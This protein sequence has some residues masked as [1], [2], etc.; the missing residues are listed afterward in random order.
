MAVAEVFAFA[1]I[2]VQVAQELE[3]V[4]EIFPLAAPHRSL[5]TGAPIV[6]L[7]GKVYAPIKCTRLRRFAAD[8]EQVDTVHRLVRL[9]AGGGQQYGRHVH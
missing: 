1:W 8:P 5:S 9:N 7:T 4:P 6:S 3:A 2:P